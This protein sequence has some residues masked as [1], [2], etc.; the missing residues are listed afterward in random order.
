V[1]RPG[2]AEALRRLDQILARPEFQEE[3]RPIW[4][5]AFI[6]VRDWLAERLLSLLDGAPAAA[7]GRLEWAQALAALVAFL[8]LIILG[9][10]V[11]RAVGLSVSREARQRAEAAARL[12]ARSDALWQ[13]GLELERAGRY[14]EAGRALYL[15]AL[16]ALEEHDLLSIQEGETNQ[17]HARRAARAAGAGPELGDTFQELVRRYDRLR[18]GHMDVDRP[19]VEELRRLAAQTREVRPPRSATARRDSRVGP[20]RGGPGREMG[21]GGVPG[22]GS[23]EAPETA[24][25]PRR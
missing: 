1:A 21:P 15:S 19:A 6:A 10:Y 23:A 8:A 5:Q 4:E 22:D 25:L 17:E 2:E 3:P 16:Y 24:A 12:R 11:F 7:L 14:A 20:D 13:E 18:Y 9:V